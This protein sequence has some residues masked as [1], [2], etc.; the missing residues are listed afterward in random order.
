M[1]KEE[2]QRKLETGCFT[3]MDILSEINGED[4][5]IYKEN[6]EISDHIIYIP[7]YFLNEIYYSR[8][9]D[10]EELRN[11]IRN[12]YTG[13]DFLDICKGDEKKAENL[14]SICRWQHPD[15]QDLYD[16]TYEEDKA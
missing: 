1:T 13:K 5:L 10:P 12:C 4:C 16:L 14:F 11:I 7:D 3:L 8:R 15:I 6:W 9:P 2:L